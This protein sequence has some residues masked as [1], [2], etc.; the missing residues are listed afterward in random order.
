MSCWLWG[1]GP[2]SLLGVPGISLGQDR[3]PVAWGGSQTPSPR[4]CGCG[5]AALPV[6]PTAPGDPKPPAHRLQQPVL[7]WKESG[8][9]WPSAFRGRFPVGCHT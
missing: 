1:A 7:F 2:G 3:C 5:E 4:P 6:Q 9:A 8:P